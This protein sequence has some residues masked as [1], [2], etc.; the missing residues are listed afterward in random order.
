MRYCKR[1]LET[2]EADSLKASEEQLEATC[3]NGMLSAH[4]QSFHWSL[5][6][7]MQLHLSICK[8]WS[9]KQSPQIPNA[10]LQQFRSGRGR[11][12]PWES[13]CIVCE[14]S[15]EVM[16]DLSISR[17]VVCEPFA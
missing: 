12:T 9:V 10:F 15:V 11:S 7:A 14:G 5:E 4:N 13:W 16:G 1:F 3:K 6:V 2:P 8:T 17:N